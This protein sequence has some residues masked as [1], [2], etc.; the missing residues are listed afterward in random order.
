MTKSRKLLISPIEVILVIMS[1]NMTTVA[2]SIS[3]AAFRLMPSDSKGFRNSCFL[4][5]PASTGC[6][7]FLVVFCSS[8]FPPDRSEC[9]AWHARS[10]VWLSPTSQEGTWCNSGSHFRIDWLH[11]WSCTT[12]SSFLFWVLFLRSWPRLVPESSG[13]PASWSSCAGNA[14][15][16][17]GLHPHSNRCQCDTASWA[18]WRH[19]ASGFR[20]VPTQVRVFSQRNRPVNNLPYELLI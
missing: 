18:P 3:N 10:C 4:C 9:C 7:S 17:W 11:P 5:I 14:S 15:L 16:S 19:R 12:A 1:C 2:N 13:Q 8:V 6:D 20:R